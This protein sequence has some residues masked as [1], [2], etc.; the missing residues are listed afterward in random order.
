MGT[1]FK[2]GLFEDCFG[3]KEYKVKERTFSF[4]WGDGWKTTHTWKNN[5]E[6]RRKMLNYVEQLKKKSYIICAEI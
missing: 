2:Y 4:I 5:E 3:V 1:E 6:G